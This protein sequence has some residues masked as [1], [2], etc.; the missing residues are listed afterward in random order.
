MVLVIEVVVWVV[1]CERA[2]RMKRR[3][4]GRAASLHARMIE[5]AVKVIVCMAERI[6]MT[7]ISTVMERRCLRVILS[8]VTCCAASL[9]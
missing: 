1:M 5:G 7:S 8:C 4:V 6:E 2:R 3:A 9:C